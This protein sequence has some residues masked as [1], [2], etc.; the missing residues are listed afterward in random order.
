MLPVAVSRSSSDCS[1]VRYVLPVLQM[2]SH[3][4]IMK[5][6]GQNQRRHM[7]CLVSQVVIPVGRQTTLFGRVCLVAA[8]SVKSAVS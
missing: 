8:P 1:A 6:I 5:G 2:M 7:F 3:S 4:Y